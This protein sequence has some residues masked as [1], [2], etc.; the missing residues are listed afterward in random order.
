VAR[1]STAH[2]PP[3]KATRAK[4][5]AAASRMAVAAAAAVHELQ[6]TAA[7]RIQAW[8]RSVLARK[9]LLRQQIRRE[10]RKLEEQHEQK[11]RA[12]CEAAAAAKHASEQAAALAEEQR[13]EAQLRAVRDKRC[14]IE[15]MCQGLPAR[16]MAWEEDPASLFEM[17]QHHTT[18]MRPWLGSHASRR[19]ARRQ[20]IQLARRW[21]PDKWAV[22]G[23]FCQ[24]VATEVTK[25]LVRAYEEAVR[26]LPTAEDA[27]GTTAEDEDEEREVWEFASWV[28]VAW[29]GMFEVWKERKGVTAGPARKS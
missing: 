19:L 15:Q 11:Q 9:L 20:Y 27:S 26:E 8:W 6:T 14:T 23:A 21:H 18:G 16:S 3:A 17:L 10:Q 2:G 28:G 7:V 22:Q 24:E 13:R 12:K 4:S 5:K 25:C 29:D 1:R